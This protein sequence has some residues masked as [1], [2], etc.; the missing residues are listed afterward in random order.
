VTWYNPLLVSSAGRH[1]SLIVI[2]VSCTVVHRN[3]TSSPDVASALTCFVEVTEV[4]KLM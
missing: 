2:H 1:V 3:N 4:D